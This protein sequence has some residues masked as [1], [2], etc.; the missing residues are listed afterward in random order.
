MDATPFP[1][2]PHALPVLRRRYLARDAEGRVVETPE[3]MLAR[4]AGAVARGEEPWGGAAAAREMERAFLGLMSQGLFLPNSPT[5]MNAGRELGQ[6]SACFVIPV[7]DSL[8]SIF[9]AVKETALIHKSGGGTGFSFSHLRP[10]GD[11][12]ASTR[13]VS[14]G[15]VSFMRVFDMATEAVKQG[16]TRRGA[17]M[18]ILAVSHPDIEAFIAAKRRPGVL[19]NFNIS[20]LV[21]DAF[22]A[23]ARADGPWQLVN[24][25]DGAVARTV[26]AAGLLEQMVQAA[27]QSGEP[28]LAFYEAINRGNP[29]PGLGPLEATNPCGEQPLLPHESCNLGSLV[30]PRFLKDGEVD[31]PT[32]EEAAAL[33]VRFLD[34]VIEINRHPLPQ[35]A[36]ASRLTRK[37]GLG[38][39]GLADLLADLEL[40]YDSPE[41][42][43]LGREVMA[44]IAAAARAASAELGQRRGSFP[45]FAASRLAGGWS[46]MRNATV[47]TVAPT[48]TLS[49]LLGCSSGI[50]P[51]FALA[52]T[53]RVLEERDLVEFNPRFLARL[54]ALGLDTPEQR[55]TLAASGNATAIQG[56]PPELGQVFATAHE[57]DPEAHL[58]MQA[59]FQASTDNGVSKTVNLD[60]QAGP[61]QVRRV[62]TRAH[63]LGLKG[64]TVFRS[65][66]RGRQVLELLPLPGREAPPAVHHSG[67]CPR[68]GGLLKTDG[69]CLACSFCGASG[70]E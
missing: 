59:A 44:R 43:A 37:I 64:V 15:P 66:C 63:A 35:V 51:Y 45:A 14:S 8:E 12:V 31:F 27:H 11:V 47:T 61:E 5:L 26:S 29:T 42:A 32:L 53:R 10:A 23:A 22:M 34:D 54:A 16:G 33:A 9:E 50:E 30:L 49:L 52:Y 4:V 2:G 40:P 70:C 13:G 62:F 68:C 17:N 38:V 60:A 21:N 36:R 55:R 24:P 46:H 1:F 48:G 67:H 58:A 3:Q 28:G 56:L 65:G 20:V 18:G 57:I 6:L 69:G 39:M 25:R 41:A 19:E 7:E